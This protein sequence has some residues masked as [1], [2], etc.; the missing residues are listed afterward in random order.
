MKIGIPGGLLFSRYEQEI[1]S[2]F[3][4]LQQSRNVE[5]EYSVETSGE[6]LD[7][8]VRFC[9]DEA[10]LPIKVF[11]GHAA[12]LAETCDAVVIPRI[13]RCEDGSS[14]CPKFS[15]LPELAARA[16]Q[17]KTMAFTRPLA[18]DRPGQV[19]RKVVASGKELGIPAGTIRKAFRA[20]VAAG[21]NKAKTYSYADG[22]F[23]EG[24]LKILLL[25]H[26]YHVHDSFA[27]RD[28]LK[29]L[30]RLGADVIP[31]ET[32]DFKSKP[33]VWDDWM[34]TPYWNFLRENCQAAALAANGASLAEKNRI[35]GVIYLS[36]F[37]CGT[38]AFTLEFVK[39]L[40]PDIPLLAVKLDEQTGE[41]GLD[42]RLEAFCELLERR[43]L[44]AIDISSPGRGVS[45]RRAVI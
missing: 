26:P 17:G 24:R 14:I 39:E 22:E 28:I 35:D 12:K 42:T 29:K 16:C 6:I 25:G 21:R 8:G 23:G 11:C 37:G 32:L 41:A 18:F 2:F 27:N 31:G 13:L 5:I 38:D 44:H 36:S 45:V 30:N 15:G 40:L 19:L 33:S 20:G 4:A 43:K 10:C 9:V 1:R 34:K 7:L 3:H